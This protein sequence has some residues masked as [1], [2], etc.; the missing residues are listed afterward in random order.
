MNTSTH[1]FDCL[2]AGGGL[3]GLLTARKLAQEGLTVA[4]LEAGALC[5]E[6]SWAGGGILSP[7]VPWQYPAAVTE[8]VRWSQHAYPALVAELLELTGIDAEW[9]RSGLLL[10]GLQRDPQVTD[11]ATRFG[12]AVEPLD[13]TQV[14]QLESALAMPAAG[15]LLLPDV[16]QVRN[17]RLCRALAAALRCLGVAIHEQSP[18]RR[19]LVQGGKVNGVETAAGQFRAGHVVIASGAWSPQLLPEGTAPLAVEPVRGQMIQFQA[20]PGLLQH[21]VLRDGHYLI[22][23]RDGLVLAGSTLEHA[24]YDRS[25]TAQGRE[26][27][28]QAA[29]NILPALADYALVNHWAGLRPGSPDGIPWI[30]EHNE[31]SGLYLNVG[32]YRNG[33]VMA[34]A[35]AQLLADCL[36][37]RTSFTG[38]APYQLGVT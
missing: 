27:L 20:H 2:V 31:I 15:G 33:V 28:L 37:R 26:A 14:A 19:L 36:L 35:S 32:H 8:L 10:Q 18:V 7:L 34:P 23:R 21:I 4:L 24:G 29:L 9:T 38:F 25:V 3:I 13:G 22:P 6:S 5:R 11:W 12:V 30:C 16:A 17:P 1:S